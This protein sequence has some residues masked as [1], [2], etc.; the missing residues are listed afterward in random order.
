MWTL[1]VSCEQQLVI[2]NN[3]VIL[4]RLGGEKTKVRRI[5]C[6][7]LFLAFAT[8]PAT[9][10]WREASSDHF[11]IYSEDSA[12]DLKA[13]ATR[14]ESFYLA[15]GKIQKVRPAK[16]GPASRLTV[17]ALGNLTAVRNLLRGKGG[18]NVAGIYIA[19]ASGSIAITSRYVGRSDSSGLTP[20]NVLLHELSHH[21]MLQHLNGVFPAWYVEGFAEFASTAD[22]TRE[23]S[24]FI[25]R[26]PSS[27]TFGFILGDG[28]AL[29]DLFTL[30]PGTLSPEQQEA[31]YRMGW[32]LTHYLTFEP[33]RKG[34]LTRY[35][36]R[37]AEGAGSLEA[38]REV[39]G[40]L[41]KL[42]LEL[43][44]YVN[45]SKRRFEV[46]NNAIAPEAVTV[47]DLSPGEEAIMRVRMTSARG[48]GEAEAREVHLDALKASGPYPDNPVVQAALAEAAFDAG[49]HTDAEAAAKR[50]L[51][52][53]PQSIKALLLAGQ[54]RA[55]LLAASK[56]RDP[57]DWDQVRGRFREAAQLDPQYAQPLILTYASYGQQGAAPPREAVEGMIR[58][59]ALAPQDD[60]LRWVAGG[61]LL[62]TG[63]NSE[64]RA[65]LA[66]LAFDPHGGGMGKM[67][68]SV[69]AALDAGGSSKAWEVWQSQAQGGN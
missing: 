50:A 69:I 41:R 43:D 20:E 38:V 55:A 47:R 45:V 7:L 5:T 34:Q 44:G 9:A 52:A 53:D 39:F 12:R 67:V 27:S 28:I 56:N 13:Y 66:P 19:R 49:R 3:L 31:F 16:P 60:G 61:L 1:I 62:Q 17:F 26:P 42:G 65:V 29:K 11:V 6:L 10:A 8:S 35:L 18:G 15:L 4:E 58:A 23:G 59:Q 40:D 22:F 2:D 51:A 46:S 64:A 33:S 48:V 25:G 36:A 37:L 30:Q 54:A 14:L 21:F 57:A 68:L 24:V 63:K 32:L